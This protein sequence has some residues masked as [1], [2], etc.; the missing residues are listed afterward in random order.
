MKLLRHTLIISTIFCALA[1]SG[2]AWMLP[3]DPYLQAKSAKAIEVPAGMDAPTPDPNLAVPE[4]EI[5]PKV[6]AE[7]H[8]PPSISAAPAETALPDKQ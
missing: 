7:G 6:L 2:C 4:G 3:D 5:A 1:H 8:L